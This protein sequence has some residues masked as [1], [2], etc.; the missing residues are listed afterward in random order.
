MKSLEGDEV[1]SQG[2]L[3]MKVLSSWHDKKLKNQVK[4]KN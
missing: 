2:D 4:F 3:L 1:T